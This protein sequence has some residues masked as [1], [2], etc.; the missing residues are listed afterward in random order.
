MGLFS[1][2]APVT[3]T[4]EPQ[5]TRPQQV[6][7]VDVESTKPVDKVR[8]A[9]VELGYRNFFLYR[10]AGAADSDAAMA[11]EGLSMMGEVGTNYG[12]HK[13]TSEWVSVMSTDIAIADGRFHNATT[14][15][16][17]PSWA[18]GSSSDLVAWACRVV[19]ERDGRDIEADGEFTVLVGPTD[20]KGEAPEFERLMGDSSTIEID[21]ESRVV[22]CGDRVRGILSITAGRELPRADIAVQLQ[23]VR[24]S[25]PLTKTAGPPMERDLPISKLAPKA[26]LRPGQTLRLPFD[27]ELPADTA[28]TA[29]AV[30]STID[31]YVHARILYAGFTSATPEKVRRRIIVVNAP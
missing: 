2:S 17:I 13:N 1:R 4:V 18:P 7:R 12:S 28:P 6:V 22:R 15:F 3:V 19:I 9:R 24:Q 26:E 11:T 29:T 21:T 27:L 30:H 14:D 5:T 31:W 25:H 23:R 10:W 8:S 20:P 16:R